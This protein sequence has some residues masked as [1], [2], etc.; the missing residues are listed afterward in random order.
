MTDVPPNRIASLSA[1]GEPYLHAPPESRWQVALVPDDAA[2]RRI[3]LTGGPGDL[4]AYQA[5][6]LAQQLILAADLL[7]PPRAPSVTVDLPL[8]GHDTPTRADEMDN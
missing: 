7:P 6:D 8:I 2:P 1:S 4:N 3:R 5:R